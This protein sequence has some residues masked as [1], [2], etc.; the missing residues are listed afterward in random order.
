MERT[1]DKQGYRNMPKISVA[2]REQR[3][4]FAGHFW[5]SQGELA[6]DLL[7]WQQSHG[8][9]FRDRP[10]LTYIDQLLK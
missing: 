1:S 9:R 10:Q 8:Q 7:L 3:L 4:R 6:S 5:R 2:I